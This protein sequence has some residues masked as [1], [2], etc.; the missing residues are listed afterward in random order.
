L[1]IDLLTEDYSSTISLKCK[2]NAGPVAVTIETERGSGGALSSKIGGK[3][4]YAGV[5]FDKIQ[6]KPDGGHVLEASMKVASGV[7]LAFKGNKG[8][9]LC[10]DYTFGNIF[11]TGVLDVKEM[12]K[13]STSA[14]LGLSSGVKFGGD[15]TYG[16]SGKTG[17]SAFNVGGSY[18]A[19]PIFASVTTANKLSQFNLA[20][21]YKVNDTLS[22]A[23]HTS[24][25]S[26]KACDVLAVGGSYKAASIGT[27]K[28]KVGSDGIL[29]ACVIR[30]VA[31]KV[32]VTGSA[33]IST[34]G[35]NFNYGL[36]IVM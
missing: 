10:V 32:T 27:I 1:P 6:M 3:F 2:T 17:V 21:L 4:S 26:A 25:S 22:L 28:A 9:D 33:S 5:S 16:L 11:A 13:F 18:A 15:L 24:H 19:G 29:S 12:S 35:E 31:P 34:S 20:L 7:T 23:S 36:G 8:A 30:E 14:S